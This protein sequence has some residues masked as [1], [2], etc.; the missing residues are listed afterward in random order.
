MATSTS[1]A[2]NKSAFI[3]WAISIVLA[4]LPLLIPV[5]ELYTVQTQ[6]FLAISIFGIIILAFELVSGFCVA[7]MLP[8][9]WVLAGVTTL[10]VAFSSFVSGNAMTALGSLF[11]AA[12]MDK[13]G[14]LK[15]LGYW[16]LIK[17]KGSFIS[18]MW[19]LFIAIVLICAVGFVMT[20]VLGFTLAYSLYRVLE[21][22]PT[23]KETHIIVM[24]TM[25]AAIQSSAYL[26]C[27]ISVSIMNGAIS[28]VWEGHALQWYTLI[29]ENSP[30]LLCGILTMAGML[31]WYKRSTKGQT[32]STEKGLAYFKKAYADLGKMSRQEKKG[33]ILLVSLMVYLMTQPLHGLDTTYAFL[34]ATFVYFL[35]GVSLADG[36]TVKSISWES[37]FTIGCFLSV[38]TVAT[39]TGINTILANAM[40]PLVSSMGEYWSVFGTLIFGTLVNFILSP[41]AMMAMLPGP[42]ISYCLQAGFDP[43]PHIYAM[44]QARDLIFFPYEYPS[45]LIL[46]SFGM[47]KMGSMIKLCTIKS[48]VFILFFV[49]VMMPLWRLLGIM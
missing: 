6:R 43:M 17:A 7:I 22:K 4:I 19:A 3:K 23:D 33:I 14:L 16:S 29:L 37:W 9:L 45:Y 20:T 27:P 1:P 38:G 8:S 44:Y 40:V 26:Y 36:E 13:T 41:F 42:I 49:V 35:P 18:T 2:Q 34:I 28:L 12:V 15:R 47:V 10:N 21:L 11:L 24:T 39:S 5:S 48:L 31:F 25:L 30:T 32:I 46:F